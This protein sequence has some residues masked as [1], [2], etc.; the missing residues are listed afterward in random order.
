MCDEDA[1]ELGDAT[2]L[3]NFED[4]LVL[5]THDECFFL[6]WSESFEV[7]CWIYLWIADLGLGVSGVTVLC[8]V[9]LHSSTADQWLGTAF[10]GIGGL[11]I[12]YAGHH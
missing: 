5:G 11:V 12:L 7:R 8:L 2:V 10:D 1:G 4:V 9:Y 6:H 3:R